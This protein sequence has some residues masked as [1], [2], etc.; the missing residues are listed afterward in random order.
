MEIHGMVFRA[1]KYESVRAYTG[2]FEVIQS[3]FRKIFSISI[4]ELKTQSQL[5][6]SWFHRMLF[7]MCSLLPVRRLK[8]DIAIQWN[9]SK[10]SNIVWSYLWLQYI[11]SFNKTGSVSNHIKNRD[12]RIEFQT[13]PLNRDLL[14][15]R[16]AIQN[17]FFQIKWIC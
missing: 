16:C 7:Y 9:N 3:L 11:F 2:N 4:N 10:A 13:L 8:F 15:E 1:N 17:R 5:K 14:Y 12:V 6:K